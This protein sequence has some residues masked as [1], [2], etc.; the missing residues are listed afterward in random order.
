[1]KGMRNPIPIQGC[2]N[3]SLIEDCSKT[4]HTT[5][6]EIFT[7][8]LLGWITFRAKSFKK[9]VRQI[10]SYFLISHFPILQK[11]S[12]LQS[13]ILLCMNVKSHPVSYSWNFEVGSYG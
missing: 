8:D 3:L 5:Y 9:S 11:K 12:A 6:D 2:K 13:F 7:I 4:Y 1:M 10:L